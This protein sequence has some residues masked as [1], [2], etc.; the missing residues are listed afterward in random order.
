LV[1]IYNS[2]KK[3]NKSF[4]YCNENNNDENEILNLIVTGNMEKIGIS[5][6]VISRHKNEYVISFGFINNLKCHISYV[7][8]KIS[9]TDLI[10]KINK[11]LS[12]LLDYIEDYKAINSALKDIEDNLLENRYQVFDIPPNAMINYKND[13]NSNF[14]NNYEVDNSKTRFIEDVYRLRNQWKES[15]LSY[16]DWQLK[17]SEKYEKLRQVIQ[18]HYPDAWTFMEFSLSVKYIINVQDFTLPFMGVLIAAPSSMKTMI[19]QLFRKYPHTFYTDNFTPSS[20]ISHIST[21]TEAELQK[22][23]MIPKMKDKVVL[24]P[25]LAPIFTSKEDDMQKV[26]G[27][28]TRL[29][30]GHGLE[31]DSGA[32]GHRKYGDTMFVWLGAAVEIPPRVWKILGT[33]GHKIYFLRPILRKK[34]LQDLIKIAKNNN[35]AEKNIEIEEALLDYLKIFDAAPEID[36]KIKLENQV[37]R[38]KWNEEVGDEQDKAI[39]YI[40]QLANLLARLRGTVYVSES[41]AKIHNSNNDQ[42]NQSQQI[43]Q[44]EGQ[45]YDT[46]FPIIEDP[47]RAVILLRNLAIGHAISQGRDH[48][49]L[50]DIPIVI[51]VALSTAP[52][53][54]VR[55]LDLLLKNDNGELTTSQIIGQLSIS[56]P[57]ATRT[58]RELEALKIGKVSNVTNYT[59]SEYKI[60]LKSEFN[61]F[62]S[63]EFSKLKEEFVPAEE[64]G[65]DKNQFDSI[66][67]HNENIIKIDKDNYDLS[68]NYSI[69]SFIDN[70]S[71]ESKE[72]RNIEACDRL[73]CHTLKQN[74]PSEGQ[75]KNN[76]NACDNQNKIKE[77]QQQ[78]SDNKY[79]SDNLNLHDQL[80]Q[81]NNTNLIVSK[82]QDQYDN[83]N[84]NII[85]STTIVNTDLSKENNNCS[86]SPISLERVTDSNEAVCHTPSKLSL[87]I[88][89]NTDAIFNLVFQELLELIKL[90]NGSSISFN[91]AIESLCK[92]NEDI[93]KYLGEKLTA[94]ENRNVRDLQLK[95][96]R[97]PKIEVIKHKPQLLI[98]WK[99]DN[100]ADKGKV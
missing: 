93:R 57:I 97:Y 24:T 69:S 30:D 14:N 28:A 12:Q 58:M 22:V 32:H 65:D 96:I 51:K 60:K 34:T 50:T 78:T 29:L 75:E 15:S 89:E 55:V 76:D 66:D 19:I 79:S 3:D 99:D 5:E 26:M 63:S 4:G 45:D 56:Q 48:L 54:R 82:K 90:A 74:L 77:L 31:N 17:V 80:L 53:R 13:N 36:N 67:E 23:D 21:K 52:L 7:P 94:R 16:E 6:F 86:L 33:L 46:D 35:F 85:T 100:L 18:K 10:N 98:R 62:K 8:R 38:V 9:A 72:N 43:R 59:N 95:V 73:I 49:S 2:D 44:I 25:E 91:S 42:N 64:D 92:N 81:Q 1:Y 37:V 20:L 39:E 71:Q 68:P 11:K 87:L 84:S 88:E 41:K 40:A 27:I 83:T 47:S 61:W 70:N